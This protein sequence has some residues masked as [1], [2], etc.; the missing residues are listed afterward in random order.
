MRTEVKRLL[1]QLGRAHDSNEAHRI[2]RV[3]RK[4][5]H[6]GGIRTRR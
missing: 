1:D 5:G 3:L 4:L 6:R 2:R